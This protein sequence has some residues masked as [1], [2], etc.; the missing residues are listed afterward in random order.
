[1]EKLETHSVIKAFN[2]L[3]D[4]YYFFE[5]TRLDWVSQGWQEKEGS[6]IRYVNHQWQAGLMFEKVD[7]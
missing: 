3:D 2:D 1:M 6:G 5:A 4:A 7:V